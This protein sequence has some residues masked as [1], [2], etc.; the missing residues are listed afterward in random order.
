MNNY[1]FFKKISIIILIFFVITLSLKF[2]SKN[3]LIDIKEKAV[4]ESDIIKKEAISI[5]KNKYECFF[6]INYIQIL[7][8]TTTLFSKPV[9][10]S[11]LYEYEIEYEGLI[12][13]LNINWKSTTDNEIRIISIKK[14]DNRGRSI[15]LWP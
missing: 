9:T 6:E 13:R 10:I 7:R 4:K 8:R 5:L 11:G 1:N 3:Y 2:L 15:V 14:I 12:E